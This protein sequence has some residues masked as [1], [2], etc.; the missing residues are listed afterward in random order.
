MTDEAVVIKKRG[1]RPKKVDPQMQAMAEAL[2]RAE[3]T[4][5]Q[6]GDTLQALAAVKVELSPQENQELTAARAELAGLGSAP[7]SN[8]GP[9]PKLIPYAGMVQAKE[10]CALGSLHSVGDVFPVDVTALWTD[11]PYVA[12][13]VTG[14]NEDTGKPKVVQNEL[15]PEPIDFRFRPRSHEALAAASLEIRRADS[16]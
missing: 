10:P 9:T 8:L 12:V 1:G 7:S 13:R 16:I 11:D 6:Q 14:I 2:A 3:A 4:I 15:A 5:K